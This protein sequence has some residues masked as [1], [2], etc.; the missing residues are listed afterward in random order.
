MATKLF[1]MKSQM[2]P[3]QYRGTGYF[4]ILVNCNDGAISRRGVKILTSLGKSSLSVRDFVKNMVNRQDE[5]LEFF[6]CCFAPKVWFKSEW[7]VTGT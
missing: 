5:H 2:T 7:T 3:D 4:P 6:W 1:T